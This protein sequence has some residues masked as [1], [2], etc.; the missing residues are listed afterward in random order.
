MP[1]LGLLENFNKIMR[2]PALIIVLLS[3]AAFGLL[4]VRVFVSSNID[5][6]GIA[7]GGISE[8][9]QVYKVKNQILSQELFADESLNH[10][11]SAAARLGFI[12]SISTI[13]INTALP[14]A[15]K[16]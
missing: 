7:M 10:I 2:K 12:S 6:S 3:F 1:S 4:I 11:A 9:T 14:I 16:Q 13:S 8:Q 5:V 15:Y